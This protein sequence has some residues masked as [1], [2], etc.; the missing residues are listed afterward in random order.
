MASDAVGTAR[1]IVESIADEA[2]AS[3]RM[4]RR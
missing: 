2:S 4:G 1:I 3:V